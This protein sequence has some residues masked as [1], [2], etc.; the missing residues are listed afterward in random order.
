M[1]QG[2]FECGYARFYAAL[3]AERLHLR[4]FFLQPP[5]V[6]LRLKAEPEVSIR[7]KASEIRRAMS[8]E[9]PALP[10][11]TRRARAVTPK[12][13]ATSVTDLRQDSWRG[14]FQVC[15]VAYA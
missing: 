15:R 7:M 3:S 11:N 5:K 12:C 13:L 4:R 14:S 10:F 8:A 9:I 6:A 1:C 2:R